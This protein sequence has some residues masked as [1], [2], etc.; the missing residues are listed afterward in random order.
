VQHTD[1][2]SFGAQHDEAAT[3]FFS[4]AGFD[5]GKTGMFNVSVFIVF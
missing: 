2:F 1:A 3:S 4:L 5:F